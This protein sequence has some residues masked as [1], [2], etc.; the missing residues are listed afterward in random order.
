MQG[1]AHRLLRSGRHRLPM[2]GPDDPAKYCCSRAGSGLSDKGLEQYYRFGLAEH[3]FA[4]SERHKSSM[5]N[6]LSCS[7]Q[8][9]WELDKSLGG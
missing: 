7:P 6:G 8:A 9:P 2:A 4:G 5:N 1:L 3:C